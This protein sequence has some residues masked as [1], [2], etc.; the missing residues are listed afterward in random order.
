MQRIFT[1][2]LS[3]ALFGAFG[4]AQTTKTEVY[5]FTKGT[6][7]NYDGTTDDKGKLVDNMITFTDGSKLLLGNVT[8]AYSGANNITVNGKSLKTIKLSNGAK[9]TYYPPEGWAVYKVTL[10]SYINYD[11]PK[12][13]N[14]GRVCY[15]KELGTNTYTAETGQILTDY[16]DKSDYA[17]N[18]DVVTVSFPTPLPEFI[19]TNTGEQ[20]CVIL[21][22][23]LVEDVAKV[24]PT[25]TYSAAQCEVSLLDENPAY[26]TLTADPADILADV[27]YTSSNE[28]VATV[29][30]DGK[31]TVI[32]RG[33]TTITATYEG[34]D[35]YFGASASY[36][37]TVVDPNYIDKTWN[38]N[39]WGDVDYTATKTTPDGLTIYAS[40][41]KTVGAGATLNLGGVASVVEGAGLTRAVS[42]EVP[43]KVKI[44]CKY[45]GGS[46][47]RALALASGEWTNVISVQPVIETE[48]KT[49]YYTGEATTLYMYSTNKGLQFYTIQVVTI[50]DEEAPEAPTATPTV[51]TLELDE[52]GNIT[53]EFNLAEGNVLYYAY[54]ED[55]V[56]PAEAPQRI[57]Y[58]GT[59]YE[60]AEGNTIS[61][62]GV[63]AGTL[64]YFVLDPA[65][66]MASE[67]A[68]VAVHEYGYTTGLVEISANAEAEAEYYTTQGI[69]VAAPNAAGVY[70]CR[71]GTE[72]SKI[73]V[74]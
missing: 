70:I 61:L 52:Q 5:D 43:G 13:G 34:N 62:T 17:S 59:T 35:N 8:K 54:T 18:P 28:A 38:Q 74:K 1:L 45:K 33:T 53:V 4:W 48:T 39:S 37:L 24:M 69:R 44:T 42:F 73:L 25:L 50:S 9:N 66:G 6:L 51:D 67:P 72:V 26:P 40:E 56:A 32:A 60:E 29:A 27:T 15:W 65:T 20:L 49:F 12:K 36:T 63:K 22:V 41:G 47:Q 46:D 16:I 30:E 7:G 19:F 64:K 58:Q 21:E 23:E 31:V 55:A 71:K 57:V 11:R 14:D 3:L 2:L 68:E 10:Y